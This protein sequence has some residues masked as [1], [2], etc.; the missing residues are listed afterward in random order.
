MKAAAPGLVARGLHEIRNT[1][2]L[3]P[4]IQSVT[5]MT[6]GLRIRRTPP[7]VFSESEPIPPTT[8]PSRDWT[9]WYP[10]RNQSV[11]DR[12]NFGVAPNQR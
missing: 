2:Q 4:A 11:S 9:S 7:V 10:R 5:D 6:I 12:R 3:I 8:V 1:D